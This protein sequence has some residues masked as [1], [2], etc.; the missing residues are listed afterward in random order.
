M[1]IKGSSM[2]LALLALVRSFTFLP[3]VFGLLWLPAFVVLTVFVGGLL[4]W[5]DEIRTLFLDLPPFSW[6]VDWSWPGL[7]S[8]LARLTTWMAL[9]AVGFLLSTM[10]VGVWLMPL[11]L[12]RLA[13]R[14][15]PQLERSGRD[16]LWRPTINALQGLAIYALA[17]LGS[18]P[19]WLIPGLGLLLPVLLLGWLNRK[20]YL[21]DV[22]EIYATPD[23]MDKV[24]R[25][26]AGPA[27]G[28]GVIMAV[29]A[30]IPFVGLLAPTLAAV[31]YA[32]L[33]LTG[34]QL[35][36]L[37]GASDQGGTFSSTFSQVFGGPFGSGASDNVTSR[38]KGTVIDAEWS[39]WSDSGGTAKR[40]SE[41]RP[42]DASDSSSKGATKSSAE[43][44]S[45]SKTRFPKDLI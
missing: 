4:G 34:L 38:E 31:A 39:E 44:N 5:G 10:L 20:I 32:H 8:L 23:E 21:F 24:R 43:S 42:P 19:L 30:F 27:W 45:A 22:L 35:R 2:P 17:W 13:R 12:D 28:L 40:I 29:L 36:R 41:P 3:S 26:L 9:L 14:D 33:G 16:S 37:H 25:D 1:M 18:L 6:L 15:Y 11:I 7:A